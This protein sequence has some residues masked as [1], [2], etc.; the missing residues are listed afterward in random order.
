MI[1]YVVIG[2]ICADLQPDGSTRLGGTALF[3]A[4][5]AHCLG[6]RTAILTACAPDFDL[7]AIPEGV[8]IFRQPS[9]ETTIFENR[10]HADGRTQ[11][12]HARA[13]TIDLRYV[14]DAWLDA[15]I[16]HIAPITQEVPDTVAALFPQAQ[17]G[18]TPQG[19]IRTVQPDK[20][21]TT[22]PNDLLALPFTGVRIVILSEEDVQSD[23]PLVEQL[24]QRIPILVLTRAER[25]A[26]VFVS[27]V[28]TDVAAFPAK[29]VDPTGAGDVFAAAFFMALQ[30]G[31]LP[32]AAARWACA[33]A[34]Y[35]IE[36]PGIS[37]LPTIRQVEERFSRG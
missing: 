18:V 4:L 20:I 30:Q 34:S 28:P 23:E 17:I 36:G 3:A 21:V 25:G 5:T 6:L 8:Q 33:A 24:A 19:W 15:P 31:Q 7:S 11:L 12:L 32:V 29:V 35:A 9:P 1:D 37:T 27:G 14:P 26:T 10:Y 2:H 22:A 16:V 13:E